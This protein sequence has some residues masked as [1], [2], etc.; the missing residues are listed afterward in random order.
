MNLSDLK[1]KLMIGT[2]L[3]LIGFKIPFS[4]NN[5]NLNKIR[6]VVKI[7]SNGIYL[8]EDKTATKGSFLEYPKAS[9]LEVTEKGFKIFEAGERDL[10]D[11]EKKIKENEPKDEEQNKIDMMTDT[12]TMFYRKKR[13][14]MES[15]FF[16]LFGTEKQQGKR[17]CFNDKKIID[18]NIKGE[19][20]LEYEFNSG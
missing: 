2:A 20:S 10:T 17:Y 12:N 8:N 5:N 6:Y 1:R 15:G 19:L 13:Y 3:K 9:L 14:Y 11:E 7:Q 18:D 16:Y 4:V